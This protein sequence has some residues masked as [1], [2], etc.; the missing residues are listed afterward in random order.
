MPRLVRQLSALLA[1][2]RNGP[3]LWAALAEVLVSEQ[4]VGG[5]RARGD[6]PGRWSA[7]GSARRPG[8]AGQRT[9]QP[10]RQPAVTLVRAVERASALGL[11][12]ADALRSAVRHGTAMAPGAGLHRKSA[13][14]SPGQRTVWLDV[15]ACFEICEASGAPIAAV[16]SRLADRLEVEQ[17]TAE[18]RET[19]LAGPRSTVRLLTWLPFIGLGL[20]MAMG[21]DPLGV[22]LG[23]PLGWACLGAG[24]V[25]VICGRWWSYALISAAART[26]SR[27]R[28]R[29][30]P[31][32]AFGR[33]RREAAGAPGSAARP[34]SGRD[35]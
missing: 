13:G 25:L 8:L 6:G 35:R 15:A 21:V 1:S 27:Q 17:D 11:P 14:L 3:V 19:A 20:G 29:A 18:L 10:Q 22:L 16:L 12:T 34:V 30:G 4:P 24:L 26:P 23:G 2:G 31:A 33:L 28:A 9:P 5:H 32:A 7:R